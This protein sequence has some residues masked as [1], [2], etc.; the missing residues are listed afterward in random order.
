MRRVYAIGVLL[1][2]FCCVA[3]AQSSDIR[4]AYATAIEGEHLRMIVTEP[5]AGR[6]LFTFYAKY[7]EDATFEVPVSADGVYQIDTEWGG[8]QFR[9]EGG[10]CIVEAAAGSQLLFKRSGSLENISGAY[11]AVTEGESATVLLVSASQDGYRFGLE[12]WEYMMTSEA[13]KQES[14]SFDAEDDW[15]DPVHL[16]FVSEGCVV[17]TEGNPSLLLKRVASGDLYAFIPT[18]TAWVKGIPDTGVVGD[19]A[20]VFEAVYGF[21]PPPTAYASADRIGVSEQREIEFR[22]AYIHSLSPNGSTILASDRSGALVFDAR[23]GTLFERFPREG[24]FDDPHSAS[25]SPDGNRI[26]FTENFFL[27]MRE[28]DLHLIDL[29][30]RSLATL[31][32][33]GAEKVLG[34][35]RDSATGPLVDVTPAWLPD[36][37]TILFQRIDPRFGRQSRLYFFST[38]EG[39]TTP[40][41][42]FLTSYPTITNLR[43]DYRSGAVYYTNLPSKR[44]DKYG[45]IWCLRPNQPLPVQ[46][47]SSAKLGWE[48]AV[49]H[50]VALSGERALLYYSAGGDPAREYVRFALVDLGNFEVLE[51][52]T[53]NHGPHIRYENATF[54]PDGSKIF[55]IY[56]DEDGGCSCLVVRDVGGG[57]SLG[58]ENTL[59]KLEDSTLGGFMHRGQ[60]GMLGLDWAANDTVLIRRNLGEKGL[61]LELEVR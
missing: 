21:P 11:S 38:A 3:A 41:T 53:E 29:E 36:S 2:V 49:L 54:S 13:G 59:L 17:R 14:D 57:P 34:A 42:E 24:G 58:T 47:L 19:T 32:E 20:A 51:L 35:N 1:S 18:D 37:R 22:G 31:T 39:E 25:W 30:S 44:D 45:G 43:I 12:R 10:S 48:Y 28:P 50:Q 61:M 4:G 56:E 23:F 8:V 60:M 27:H 55:Y 40:V 52:T 33:D 7:E 9:F 15:G 26:V 46:I 5:R 16:N 6:Y